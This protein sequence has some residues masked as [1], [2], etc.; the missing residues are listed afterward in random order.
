MLV[1]GVIQLT[2][3]EDFSINE[4]GEHLRFDELRE[5]RE[6]LLGLVGQK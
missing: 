6:M 3:V 4:R 1:V 2:L 5:K